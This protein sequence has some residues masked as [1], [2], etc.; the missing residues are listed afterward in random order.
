[1][2]VKLGNLCYVADSLIYK[3]SGAWRQ[4]NLRSDWNAFSN[5]RLIN[6]YK[7]TRF[8]NQLATGTWN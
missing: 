4:A 2:P 7:A 5:R 3:G 8:N 6:S 1:M